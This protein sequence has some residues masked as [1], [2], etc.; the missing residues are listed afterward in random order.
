MIG[1]PFAEFI[2]KQN[3]QVSYTCVCHRAY[4]LSHRAFC[5]G[6][7]ADANLWVSLQR[8]IIPS[9]L[10]MIFICWLTQ[11]GKVQVQLWSDQSSRPNDAWQTVMAAILAFIS[12]VNIDFAS[13]L[14]ILNVHHWTS[15]SCCN[16]CCCFC[17][18]KSLELHFPSPHVFRN[19]ITWSLPAVETCPHSYDRCLSISKESLTD[20]M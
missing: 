7:Q 9:A 8:Y 2:A 18:W 5:Q 1:L 13:S 6:N 14:Q 3:V 4:F 16:A 15:R 19:Q 17:N 12:S 20:R 10:C 11:T